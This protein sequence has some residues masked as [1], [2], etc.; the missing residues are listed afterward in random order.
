MSTDREV[1]VHLNVEVPDGDTRTADELADTIVAALGYAA[2]VRDLTIV[3]P[4]AEEV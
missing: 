4:M 3:C 1:L 2:T